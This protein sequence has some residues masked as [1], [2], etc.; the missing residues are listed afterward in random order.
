MVRLY[1]SLKVAMNAIGRLWLTDTIIAPNGA[2][3]S[4]LVP[5]C[6]LSTGGGK[7]SGCRVKVKVE[8]IFGGG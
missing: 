8:P 1:P 7:G 5:P 2:E 4:A 6:E 3:S